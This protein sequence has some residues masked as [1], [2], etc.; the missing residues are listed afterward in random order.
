MHSDGCPVFSWFSGILCA[1]IGPESIAILT[2]RAVDHK[3]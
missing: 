2:E 3:A 1:E